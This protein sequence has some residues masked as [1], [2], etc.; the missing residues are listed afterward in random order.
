[1]K[2]TDG[3]KYDKLKYFFINLTDETLPILKHLRE[4]KSLES[5][6]KRGELFIG[7]RVRHYDT[8]KIGTVIKED[9]TSPGFNIVTVKTDYGEIL[10]HNYL[11]FKHFDKSKP[12]FFSQ[13]PL[14][15]SSNEEPSKIS[16]KTQSCKK[17]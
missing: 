12:N 5:A 10:S 2:G 9:K 13:F 1:M 6:R 7:D 16:K 11:S 3:K 4:K 14:V 17:N 15:L 8:G